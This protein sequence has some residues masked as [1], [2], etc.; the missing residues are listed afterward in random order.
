MTSFISLS[1]RVSSETS[2]RSSASSVPQEQA[3]VGFWAA[4][5]AAV[6]LVAFFCWLGARDWRTWAVRRA[7]MMGGSSG[8]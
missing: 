3:G 4:A 7:G 8:L 5:A 1:A 2:W 6:V